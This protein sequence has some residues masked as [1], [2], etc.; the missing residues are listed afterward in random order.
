[1]IDKSK[2]DNIA[3]SFGSASQSYDISARLQRFSG[4][5]LMPWLPKRHDITVLDLGCGTG[6]FT[7]I[8]AAKYQHV[9]GVDIS[10]KMLS[11][12]HNN[13]NKMITWLEGD[14]YHL[15]IADQSIDL[16]Y[17]NLMI[18]WCDPLELVL[19]EVLRVLKPGGLFV[20]STLLDGTLH[21]LKS[22]WKAVDNDRHVIDFKSLQELKNCFDIPNAK[23]LEFHDKPVV[24]EYENVLHLARELKGLGAN[25]VPEKSNRGLAGKEKWQ[26]MM[27][28][29]AQF[30]E[31]DNIFPATYH[32]FSGLM[33]KLKA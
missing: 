21:E 5:N 24:L 33:V 28:A 19:K 23:L 2:R 15:P 26:K 1:M 32:V 17:S 27:T 20:F 6:F 10:A 9:I 29:Y 22:S 25:H 4:K 14:A 12:A 3:K 13:R 8:L 11:Y 18:Q 30:V 16:V 31:Q 7:D